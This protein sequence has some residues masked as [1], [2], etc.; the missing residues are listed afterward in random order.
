MNIDD[1][2]QNMKNGVEASSGVRINSGGDMALRLYAVAA[3]IA[4]LWTQAEWIKKQSFPKT[5]T[6]NFLDNHAEVRSLS[7]RSGTHARGDIRF[8]IAEK[9]A[10]AVSV[11][12]GT[13]CLN[14]AGVEFLT[15]ADAEITVGEIYCLAAATAR[16]AGS[17]GNVPADS[18][19]QMT[20]APTGITRCYN[21]LSFYGGSDE[22]DDESL[23]SRVMA[24]FERLPNGSNTAYYETEALNTDGVA[25]VKVLPRNRGL[26]TVDLVIS[27]ADGVPADALIE[28]LRER[29]EREREIC[30]D[31]QV[32]SP[33]LVPVDVTVA[34]DVETGQSPDL[35]SEKVKSEL[36]KLFDGKLL[37]KNLLL[38]KLGSVIFGVKG[39]ANYAI[40]APAA[41]VV[42]GDKE[43]PVAGEITVSGR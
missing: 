5:A 30:V 22:E 6:G 20:L 31:I 18:I 2:Y 39:V 35:V 15:D 40:T 26:G 11:P 24:S 13:V 4:S 27:S 10:E 21:P 8:E 3:E 7:R 41:D 28:G 17:F 33:S 37:G 34:V 29:L 23:R 12:K 43:L 36:T 19:C 42:I 9:R 38:A 16:D 25:A 1:I 14:S 32:L